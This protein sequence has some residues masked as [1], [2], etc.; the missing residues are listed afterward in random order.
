MNPARHAV[1][2]LAA[3]LALGG[4]NAPDLLRWSE[5]VRLSDGSKIVLERSVQKNN[6][7]FLGTRVNGA[8]S[9]QVLELP[10]NPP[11]RWE[12]ARSGIPGKY[13]DGSGQQAVAPLGFD[14]V[15]GRWILATSRNYKDCDTT[16]DDY[17]VHFLAWNGT[18]WTR[19]P[20]TDALLDGTSYNLLRLGHTNGQFPV[21]D[22]D[23][24]R[25]DALTGE[26]F[27]A[28]PNKTIRQF[29]DDEDMGTC[30]KVLD[31]YPAVPKTP[32]PDVQ[33]EEAVPAPEADSR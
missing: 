11:V 24:E 7:T 25:K 6:V 33:V 19:V 28:I 31:K 1:P 29:L 15:E 32:A 4:C 2:A 13:S 9:D 14:R 20:Q 30:G 27:Q 5:Q 18:A 23:L 16:P 12:Q 22:V 3:M 8:L 17:L 26:L 21:G 10:G